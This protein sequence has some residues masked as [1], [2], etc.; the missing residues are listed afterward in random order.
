MLLLLI[1]TLVIALPFDQIL[2]AVVVHP[3]IQY[4]LNFRLLLTID[5]S[6]DGVGTDRRPGM[7]SGSMGDSLT[8]GNM[9]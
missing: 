8:T 5:K 6:W 2:E 1:I 7:G 3:A 9:G 4:S